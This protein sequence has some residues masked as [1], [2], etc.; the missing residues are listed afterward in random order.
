MQKTFPALGDLRRPC[1]FWQAIDDCGR[2]LDGM[3]HFSL[4]K[5]RVSAD[6]LDRD[7][8]AV[9]GKRLVLDMSGAFAVD[10]VA[11]I[12]AELFQVDLVDPAADLFVRCEED[13]D[14]AVLD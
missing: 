6:A 10:G 12:R 9:G 1:V 7:G 13:F 3:L 5:S 4:G 8:S 2:D 14:G 11:E